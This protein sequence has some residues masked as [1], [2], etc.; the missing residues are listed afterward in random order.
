MKLLKLTLIF[1]IAGST[2]LYAQN[3]DR[4]FVSL[5]QKN[6]IVEIKTNDG[7]YQIKPYSTKI[8]ETSF[9][10]NSEVYNPNSHAVVLN[11]ENVEFN[12]TENENTIQLKTS[13][14]RVEIRKNP[15][16]IL[17]FYKNKLL[18]SE[19]KGYVK[20][21][22][23]ETLDFNLTANEILYGGGARALGMN[24]RGNRLQLYNRAH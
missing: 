13:G 12:V 16:Q 24:R 10:S 17:Y 4:K 18:I 19:R 11:P 20:T 5:S 6:A 22:E 9:I 21:E 23:F 3:A 2:F 8:A 7:Y 14:I 1:F 15:F